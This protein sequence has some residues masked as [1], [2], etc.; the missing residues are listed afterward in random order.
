MPDVAMGSTAAAPSPAPLVFAGGSC[1]GIPPGF[2]VASAMIHS[3]FSHLLGFMLSFLLGFLLGF[4]LD[5]L[6]IDR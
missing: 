6:L 4:L 3:L 2:I 1:G 5:H